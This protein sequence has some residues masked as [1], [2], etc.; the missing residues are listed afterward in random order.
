ML[1]DFANVAITAN[2]AYLVSPFDNVVGQ[3]L[4]LFGEWELIHQ[5]IIKELIPSG[6]NALYL[7]V[8]ANIGAWAVPLGKHSAGGT[9][10]AFEA[11]REVSM[12][13]GANIV[14]N[15]LQNVQVVNA[16]IGDKSG[17]QPTIELELKHSLFQYPEISFGTFSVGSLREALR[18]DPESIRTIS[19][20]GLV[21]DEF[22]TNTL[23]RCPDF[24]KMD[25]ENHEFF[26]LKGARR[27]LAECRPVL[28]LEMGCYHLNKSI[29]LFLDH[30]GYSMSWLFAPFVRPD[31]NFNGVTMDSI[32]LNKLLVITG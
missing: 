21:L 2:G 5:D 28:L 3:Y 7:D 20:P 31:F 24:I 25:I 12:F 17:D 27:M 13:L 26:A 22:Y 4:Q 15:G 23:K 29:I 19:T 14:M 1:T 16:V 9:V 32:L 18:K 11:T 30:L 8:G 6:P 10:V